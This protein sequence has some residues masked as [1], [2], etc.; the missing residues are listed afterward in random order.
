MIEKIIPTPNNNNPA[1]TIGITIKAIRKIVLEHSELRKE[2]ASFKKDAIKASLK[3]IA[4]KSR[5][6]KFEV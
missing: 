5:F 1:I 6:A 4:Q 3:R 2:L